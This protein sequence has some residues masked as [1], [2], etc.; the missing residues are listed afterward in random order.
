[1]AQ[2][3]EPP[4]GP[5]PRRAFFRHGIRNVRR[6]YS[7]VFALVIL[8]FTGWAALDAIRW[9][10]LTDD[11]R[12]LALAFGIGALLAFVVWR[13]VDLPLSRELR[14]ARRGEAARGEVVSLRKSRGKRP[15]VLVSYRF[16]TFAGVSLTGEC[17]LPR[18]INAA[19]WEPG[20]ELEILYDVAN[21]R[22]NRPRAALASIE[23][24]PAPLAV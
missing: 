18:R 19:T 9:G 17:K 15:R 7:T 3:P 23:F 6:G 24:R 8:V 21:P 5:P 4:L 12:V 16:R 2:S 13:F 1:M 10:E 14:L 11:R 22:I 20:M